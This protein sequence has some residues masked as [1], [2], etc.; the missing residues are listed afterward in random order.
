MK[1]IYI[2][3]HLFDNESASIRNLS[4]INGLIENG[5]KVDIITLDYLASKEDKFLKNILKE[6]EGIKRVKIPFYNFIQNQKIVKFR[7]DEKR[8]KNYNFF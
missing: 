8:K 6:K 2:A 7:N 3:S 1:L 4:L 5:V